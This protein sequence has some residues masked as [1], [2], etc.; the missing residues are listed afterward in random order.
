MSQ[1]RL[2][3]VAIE[4]ELSGALVS[5]PCHCCLLLTEAWLVETLLSVP[6]S[7]TWLIPTASEALD[8]RGDGYL[9]TKIA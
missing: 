6:W 2:G 1:L 7:E 8:T 3:V 4:V 5:S 9:G